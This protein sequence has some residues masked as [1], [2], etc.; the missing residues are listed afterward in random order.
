MSLNRDRF[1][2]YGQTHPPHTHVS[3]ETIS[4]PEKLV[5]PVLTRAQFRQAEQQRQQDDHS[6]SKSGT[7]LNNPFLSLEQSGGES[8]AEEDTWLSDMDVDRITALQR[9]V[10]LQVTP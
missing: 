10:P 4:P 7:V 1:S 5:Q 6:T 2:I 3:T 9:D 8:I